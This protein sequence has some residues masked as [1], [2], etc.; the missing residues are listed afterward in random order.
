VTDPEIRKPGALG[1]MAKLKPLGLAHHGNRSDERLR[2]GRMDL[3]LDFIKTVHDAGM[4]AGVSMH[5]PAVLAYV[6]EQGWDVDF[7]MTCLYRVSRT[8][9]ET[10]AEFGEAPLGET[11][12]ERDPERMTAMVRQTKRTCFAFKLLGAGRNIGRPEV[13]ERAFRFALTNIKP[14]DAVIV[15]M[16]PR[17]KDEIAENVALVRKICGPS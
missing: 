10:R 6:E 1:E 2:E 14:Q 8:V 5:N 13:L 3:V 16:C 11:F 4:P 17:F 9:E 7:Y 15:G 12:M